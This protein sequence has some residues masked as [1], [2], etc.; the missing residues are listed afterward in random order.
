MSFALV[1]LPCAHRSAPTFAS[2]KDLP[3]L[4][5]AFKW[6]ARTKVFLATN[7]LARK[8]EALPFD[9]A[10]NACAVA[11][12]DAA[13]AHCYFVMLARCVCTWGGR[14]HARTSGLCCE[15][16]RVELLLRHA[17][18]GCAHGGGP[19]QCLLY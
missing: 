17:G 6:R 3:S 10:W 2:P 14:V 11:L 13:R 1:V 7:D 9:D 15:L 12:V 19:M 4:V 5:Q 18:Q 16:W 8:M